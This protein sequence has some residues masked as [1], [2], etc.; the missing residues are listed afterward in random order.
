FKFAK[1][2]VVPLKLFTNRTSLFGYI[3]TFLHSLVATTVLYYL[4][5]YF[6]GALLQGPIHSG[7]SIFGNAFTIAPF[8][9]IAGATVAVFKVYR[10]QNLVGWALMTIGV[11]LLSLLK[12]STSKGEWVGFQ[13]IE[14]VGIGILF[15]V[16]TFPVLAALPLAETAHALAVFTFLRTYAQTWGV[17]IGATILQNE[18]KKKLPEAFLSVVSAHGAEIAYAAIPQVPHLP[19]PLRT[20]VQEAFADSLKVIWYVLAAI[21]AVGFLLVFAVKELP[22]ADVTD[23][24]WGIDE[25]AKEQDVEKA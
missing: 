14:G 2:P 16:T 1:E 20:Q 24:H 11:G 18:L 13:L 15:S 4:P 5:V 22:M 3:T 21:S 17:T 12:A 9:M 6:Q 23:E 8:A 19:E 10:P 7:V 25:K